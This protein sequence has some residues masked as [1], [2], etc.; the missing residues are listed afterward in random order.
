MFNYPEGPY[1][2]RIL[3]LVSEGDSVLDLGCGI[4]A[5][6]IML[7]PFCKRV[8][9]MDQDKNALAFLEA[10][11]RKLKLNNI[12]T[13]HDVWP[14]SAPVN[15]DI[16]IALHVKKAMYSF[17]NLK[18]VFESA[19][20]GGFIACQA[21]IS[22]QDEPFRELK[23]ALGITPRSENCENGCYIMGILNGMGA[24]VSCEKK[25][26]EFGQPLDTAEDA[27]SFIAWQVDA[28]DSMIQTVGQYMKR[29][30]D[31]TGYGKYLVQIKRHCC[32]ITFLK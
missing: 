22:V 17:T 9:A 3:S 26:Y 1:G 30:T 24:S 2:K 29:Y 14:V 13:I 5:A 28:D 18:L 23:E 12:E 7:S 6:S 32:G 20:R 11:A 8:I 19:K 25:V 10:N 31:K 16:V 15:T 4:G 27:V 21:P